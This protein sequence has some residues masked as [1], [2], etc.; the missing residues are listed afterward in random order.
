MAKREPR[1]QERDVHPDRERTLPHDLA[2]EKAVIGAILVSGGKAFNAAIGILRA[3]HF[4]RDGHRRIF[5]AMVRLGDRN[6]PIDFL[7]IKAELD[8]TGELDECG[9]PAY[10]ASLTDGVPR[11]SNLP[12]YANIVLEHYTRRQI[13]KAASETLT[14]AYDIGE[15]I[16][17]VLSDADRAFLALQRDGDKDVVRMGDVVG[18]CYEELEYREQHRGLLTGVPSGFASIDEMTSG[19]QGGDFIIIAARPSMG[20]TAFVLNVAKAASQAGKHVVLFSLEMKRRRLQNRMLAHLSG[21]S[22]ERIRTGFLGEQDYVALTAGTAAFSELNI[23]ISDRSAQT[24]WDIRSTCRQLHAEKRCDMIIVDYFQLMDY[25][26]DDQGRR[27]NTTRNEELESISRRM[28]KLAGE[29]NVPL[30]T[31]SQLSRASEGRASKRPTLADLRGTGAL[32]QDGDVVAFL[33][34]DDHTQSGSTHF[35]LEKQRDGATGVIELDFNRYTQTFTDAGPAPEPTP[36]APPLP[37]EGFE[38][39]PA[40][41]QHWRKRKSW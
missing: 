25:D 9:G 28:K 1:R 20:K 12:H 30:I 33:H 14:S 5:D 39:R 22:V 24:I 18:E 8:R 26:E 34:R 27:R 32:E 16:E 17:S 3:D 4:F 40:T 37:D 36:E 21:V 2:C 15:P 19:W 31:L 11:S 13:I 35:I 38:R 10:I 29:L 23:H 6:D 41:K 7:T